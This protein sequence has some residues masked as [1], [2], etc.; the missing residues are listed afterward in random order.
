MSEITDGRLKITTKNR[1]LLEIKNQKCV[2]GLSFFYL[3]LRLEVDVIANARGGGHGL[4]RPD[5][6]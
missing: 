3:V 4:C 5:L 6:V 2:N 1:F